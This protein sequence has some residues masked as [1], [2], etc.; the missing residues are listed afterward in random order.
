MNE[1]YI[2]EK[3]IQR[4][5]EEAPCALKRSWLYNV[6]KRQVLSNAD[7]EFYDDEHPSMEAQI[8]EY[9]AKTQ[10]RS[11]GKDYYRLD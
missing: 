3:V 6:P 1:C 2:P 9:Y 10:R 5:I 7:E 4:S 8:A 11:L